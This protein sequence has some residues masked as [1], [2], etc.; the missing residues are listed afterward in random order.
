MNR[1]DEEIK[2]AEQRIAVMKGAKEGKRVRFR[3]RVRA[4]HPKSPKPSWSYGEGSQVTDPDTGLYWDWEDYE[5]EIAP[6][7]LVVWVNMYKGITGPAYSCFPTEERALDHA[8]RSILQPIRTA[9]K[10]EEDMSLFLK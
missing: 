3:R 6:E 5:Y 2:K 7:P 4:A 10:C 9:I 8:E 1:I